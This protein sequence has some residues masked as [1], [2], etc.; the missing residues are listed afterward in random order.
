MRLN[1]RRY[2]YED[3]YQTAIEHEWKDWIST[4]PEIALLTPEEREAYKQFF[5]KI[6]HHLNET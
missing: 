6:I 5:K 4:F 1:A 2:C 3:D